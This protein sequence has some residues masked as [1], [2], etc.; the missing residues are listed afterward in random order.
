M[1]V[2]GT[3]W[4]AFAISRR[5]LLVAVFVFQETNG[6]VKYSWASILS[7]LFLLFHRHVEPFLSGSISSGVVERSSSAIS[8][9][10]S[11]RSLPSISKSATFIQK[12]QPLFDPNTLEYASLALLS[13][14]TILRSGILEEGSNSDL[15]VMSLL[16]WPFIAV[17]IVWLIS[18]AWTVAGTLLV[19]A[20]NRF[21]PSKKLND[22]PF[23]VE[24]GNDYSLQPNPLLR[25][26]IPVE[27]DIP[28]PSSSS[29]QV[30]SPNREPASKPLPAGFA[31]YATEDG[32]PYYFNTQTKESLWEK[33]N[34]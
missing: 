2:F 3:D 18:A 28:T 10:S 19:K 4:E 12:L 23:V 15:V 8:T 16:V 5:T 17:L 14:M 29:L 26:D 11:Q 30:T 9:T 7:V 1:F 21:F 25:A 22:Q 6:A 20:R 27:P 32:V 34:A 33:P 13:L 24:T 31:E